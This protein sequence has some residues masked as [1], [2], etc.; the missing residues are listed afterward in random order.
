VFTSAL[1]LS[2]G[3]LELQ[4]KSLSATG[5]LLSTWAVGTVVIYGAVLLEA[6]HQ[7]RQAPAESAYAEL[8]PALCV[9]T[10]PAIARAFHI[11]AHV[12]AAHWPWTF[13]VPFHQTLASLTVL[14][15]T[16]LLVWETRRL[17][18]QARKSRNLIALGAV[19]GLSFAFITKLGIWTNPLTAVGVDLTGEAITPVLSGAGDALKL[20]VFGVMASAAILRERMLDLSL[21]TRRW[22]AR[23]LVAFFVVSGF[24]MLALLG[25]TAIDIEAW[26]TSPIVMTLLVVTLLSTQGFRRLVDTVAEKAYAVPRE[27]RRGDQIRAYRAAVEQAVEEER[28]L[29]SD[30]RLRRLREELNLDDR[31]AHVLER[32][33][34]TSSGG[35]LQPGETIEG[36]Y[37]IESF[38]G[39]GSSGRVFRAHDELLDR[40]VAIKEVL[41]GGPHES[42]RALEEAR[43]AGRS[44]HPNIATM[45]DVVS[46]AGSSLIVAEYVDGPSLAERVEDGGP[47]PVDELFGVLDGILSGLEAV[48]DRD[49]VHGD[50]KPAN[51]L[52]DAAGTPKIADFGTSRLADGGT[53]HA[54]NGGPAP[55]GTPA[56]MA[57]EQKRGDPATKASDIYAVGLLGKE[58]GREPLPDPVARVLAAARSEDPGERYPSATAMRE[59]LRE[60]RRATLTSGR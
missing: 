13:E 5:L 27:S 16:G 58:V 4:W 22:A 12:F 34:G 39:R 44:D 32:M 36:R 25:P 60:A 7:T 47:L 14:A 50:L 3:L 46:R 9:I 2:V 10:V 40:D 1:T 20:F 33:A 49:V 15:V 57:P 59:A 28:V 43:M 37:R 17:P 31:T 24:G 21:G 6:L 35:P 53:R 45:H 48:H 38:V 30:P 51:V 23:V 11:V 55:E 19:G 18:G 42:A 29:G 52:I 54:G 26:A 56:Y 8:V 41:H